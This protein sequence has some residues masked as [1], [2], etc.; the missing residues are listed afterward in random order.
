MTASTAS[1]K[2]ASTVS[3]CR[4]FTAATVTTGADTAVPGSSDCATAA[5][6]SPI[7]RRYCCGAPSACRPATTAPLSTSSRRTVTA[8][9]PNRS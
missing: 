9:W 1:E 8:S 3:A 2:E 4:A 6:S 5:A 7:S